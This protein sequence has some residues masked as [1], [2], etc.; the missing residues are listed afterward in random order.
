MNAGK[1][2]KALINNTVWNAIESYSMIGIQ[3]LCTFLLARFL[4]PA[5]FGIAGM[6]LVFTAISQTFVDSGFSVALI[7]EKTIS[8]E[9]YSSVFYLNMIIA[10]FLYCLLSFFSDTIA[11]FYNQPILDKICKISFLVLPLNALNIVQIT[12]LKRELKFKKLCIISV[13]ASLLS[14]VLALITAYYIKNVW[15]LIIQNVSLFFFRTLFLWLSSNWHPTL[16]FSLPLIKK[17][18]SFSKNILIAGLIGSIFNNIYSL[19]IGKYYTAT[20]LGYY[21]QADRFKNVASHTSTGV[22]QNVTYPILSRVYNEGGNLLE[23]YKKIICVTILFV[24]FIMSIVIGDSSDLFEILMGSNKWRRSGEYLILL[25]I[26]G[27]LFPLHA[28]NQNILMVVGKSKTLM[29]LEIARR[30]IMIIIIL[31]T[32][33]FNIWV[34]VFGNS[35]YSIVLLFLNMHFCGRPINYSVSKQ[36]KDVFPLLMRHLL[37]IL[38]G[39]LS[40]FIFSSINIFIR[41]FVSLLF[42]LIVSYFLF[43]NNIYFIEIVSYIQQKRQNR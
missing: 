23:V 37:I 27:I 29:Y 34:F 32:I 19:L 20:D 30:C 41:L 8:N 14:S 28:V 43:R 25:G 2:K 16:N 39:I 26:S 42:M 6:L 11:N 21:S 3:L 13:I 22:V 9:D 5:D 12:I 31:L 17:H 33:K 40:S 36:L 15:A 38:T 35:I 18:F 7:R 4:T 10:I 1:Y 24:G